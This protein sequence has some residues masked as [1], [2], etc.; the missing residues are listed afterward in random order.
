MQLMAWWR[1][2]VGVWVDSTTG[3]WHGI[4]LFC[5]GTAT[6]FLIP[7]KY[8]IQCVTGVCMEMGGMNNMGFEHQDCK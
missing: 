3:G 2:G 5:W 6:D 8:I 7:V 1:A 4:W